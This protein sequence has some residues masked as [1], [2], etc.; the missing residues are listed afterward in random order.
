LVTNYSQDALQ[1]RV[2]PLGFGRVGY[3]LISKS[4][5]VFEKL[6]LLSKL[7]FS[8][9]HALQLSSDRLMKAHLSSDGMR[10]A[11]NQIRK[12]KNHA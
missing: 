5:I 4:L 7:E 12:E 11:I 9:Q 3:T 10:K 2:R 8:S 1:K 6:T